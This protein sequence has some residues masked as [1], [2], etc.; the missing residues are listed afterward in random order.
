MMLRRVTT[1]ALLLFMASVV[2]VAAQTAADSADIRAAALDYVEG[3]YTGDAARMERA[4]HPELVKRIVAT[5]PEGESK[6]NGM[7]AAQLVEAT[8]AGYGRRTPPV[9]QQKDVVILDIFRNTAVVKTVMRDWIDY[10]Q[11]ARWNGR[12]VIVN[13]LWQMKQ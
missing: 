3:W 2:P 8:R 5:T 9:E 13:V 6:L 10:M 12:W 4:V 1:C 7:T 11:M